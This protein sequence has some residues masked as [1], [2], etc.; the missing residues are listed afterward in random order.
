MRNVATAEAPVSNAFTGWLPTATGRIEAERIAAGFG[1]GLRV[2]DIAGMGRSTPAFAGDDAGRLVGRRAIDV[3]AGDMG[4]VAREQ[5]RRRLAVAPAGAD[6]ARPEDDGDLVFQSVGH[7]VGLRWSGRCGDDP[8]SGR[9]RVAPVARRRCAGAGFDRRLGS[10]W[11]GGFAPMSA[12]RHDRDACRKAASI[13]SL[14][15]LS[16]PP[17]AP[18]PDPG[19]FPRS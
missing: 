15:G 16:T 19:M 12:G 14:C 6:R 5:S 10:G 18:V 3:H 2:R 13:R 11:R 7:P 9:E 4:T 8:E 17:G 1:D